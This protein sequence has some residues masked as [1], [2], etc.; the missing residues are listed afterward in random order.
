MTIDFCLVVVT[1]GILPIKAIC[2]I[3]INLNATN[4]MLSRV[5]FFKRPL[6][7]SGVVLILVLLLNILNL[8]LIAGR[9]GKT[10]SS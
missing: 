8:G 4:A 7:L 3:F 9:S 1:N 10:R 6:G 5:V 2:T